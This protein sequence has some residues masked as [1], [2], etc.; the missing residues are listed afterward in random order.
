MLYTVCWACRSFASVLNFYRTGR[1]HLVEDVC[2]MSFCDDLEYWGVDE[3]WPGTE[4]WT[5]STGASTNCTWS[6]AASTAITR[7]LITLTSYSG[8]F[9]FYTVRTEP[10]LTQYKK[11]NRCNEVLEPIA[12]RLPAIFV[13]DLCYRR[14]KQLSCILIL[15]LMNDSRISRDFNRFYRAMLCIRG[16]SHGPMSVCPSVSVCHKSEFY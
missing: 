3:Y 10:L 14:F 1:L 8:V 4:Y 16:T 5:L 7:F 15:M 9:L 6:L 11:Q 2:V 13:L 12:F